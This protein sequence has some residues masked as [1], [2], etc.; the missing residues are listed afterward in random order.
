MITEIIIPYWHNKDTSNILWTSNP[1]PSSNKFEI[2]LIN[3]L[4]LT[5][6]QNAKYSTE[7]NGSL[8]HW[9]GALMNVKLGV[10]ID[11]CYAIMR[12]STYMEHPTSPAYS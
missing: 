12:L 6:T 3:A 11:L 9:V 8:A 5:E 4:P 7:H 10:R 1:F 2:E